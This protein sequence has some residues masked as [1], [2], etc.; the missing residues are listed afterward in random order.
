MA[1]T[2]GGQKDTLIEGFGNADWASQ[3][4][5]HS[6]SSFLFHYGHGAVSWSSK[7]QNIV[8]LSSTEAKYVAQ[9]HTAKEGIWLKGFISE[10]YGGEEKPL[11]ISCNNQGAIALTNNNKFHARTK[12]IDLCYSTLSFHP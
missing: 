7:K 6:I 5:R 1:Y 4:H 9:T 8:S 12:H 2:F 3:K 11:T 10:I